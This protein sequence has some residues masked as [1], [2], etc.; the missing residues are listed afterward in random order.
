MVKVVGDGIMGMIFGLEG[1]TVLLSPQELA[2][3]NAQIVCKEHYKGPLVQLIC[4][5]N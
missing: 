3:E 5:G 4:K 2:I 1:K